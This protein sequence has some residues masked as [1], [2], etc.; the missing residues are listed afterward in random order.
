MKWLTEREALKQFLRDER[1]AG[2]TVGL[3]PTMG[4]LHAGHL[5]LVHAARKRC[6]TVLAT[7]FV[8]PLQFNED[9]DLAGYPR[10]EEADAER[11]RGDGCDALFTTTVDAMYP[12]GFQTYVVQD[13]L[14]DVLEG[15]YRPGH[16]RGVLTV[17]LKLFN[18]VRPDEA[19][20]GQKDFQQTVA[21]RRMVRDLDVPVQVRVCPTIRDTDGIA[22]SSRNRHLSQEERQ[23]A[24]GLNRALRAAQVRFAE[25]ERSAEALAVRMTEVLA[26]HEVDRVD[27][28]AVVDPITLRAE[29]VLG[30][31]AVAAI[32]AHVGRTRL[33][34]NLPLAEPLLVA[35]P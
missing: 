35:T 9:A 14:F 19:F 13:G 26:A 18:L 2:R 10:E 6:D 21:I 28:A 20:F 11:L 8:N 7:V 31:D 25:G 34:D 15:E 24:L 30:E 22:L 5:S 32:A 16:F 12:E 4:A 17:V 33:I 27:Y 29:G 3:V 23:R 1:T